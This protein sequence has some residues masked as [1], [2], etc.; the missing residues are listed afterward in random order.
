MILFCISVIT[1]LEV[2]TLFSCSL[3]LY[4]FK[5]SII[6]KKKVHRRERNFSKPVQASRE[7][8]V[9]LLLHISIF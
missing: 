5:L 2:L 8:L 9:V 4:T 3:L 1:L 7:V 6:K